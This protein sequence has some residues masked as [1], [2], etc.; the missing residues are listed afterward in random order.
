MRPNGTLPITG[1]ALAAVRAEAGRF[2]I[3]DLS[4]GGGTFLREHA[5]ERA[6]LAFVLAGSVD[7]RF[8]SSAHLLGVSQAVTMPAGANHSDRFATTGARMLVIEPLS[9]DEDDLGPCKPLFDRISALSVPSPI[10]PIWR[11]TSELR[12]SDSAAPLAL[13]ALVLDLVARTIRRLKPVPLS[14]RPPEWLAVVEERLHNWDS[15]PVRVATLADDIGVH[16][17]HLARVFRV[18][19]GVPLAT[20]LR[21]LRLDWAAGQLRTTTSIADISVGAGFV[22]QSHFTRAFRAHTGLTPGRYRAT[23]GS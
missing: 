8:A 13:E 4:F 14:P 11:L 16:P 3:S 23:C 20:Y 5:H 18:H 12:A 17:V 22:D 7:K 2:A 19:H 9:S 6:C 10:G 15:T 21:G 1:G